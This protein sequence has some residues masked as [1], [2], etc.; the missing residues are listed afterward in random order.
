MRCKAL[1]LTPP[2]CGTLPS[3]IR[4][5]TSI[6]LPCGMVNNRFSAS[7]TQNAA[8]TRSTCACRAYRFR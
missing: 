6:Q 4:M 3:T 8:A 7:P 2:Q 5:V 1:R